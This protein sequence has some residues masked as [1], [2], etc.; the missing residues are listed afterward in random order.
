VTKTW[1]VV[2]LGRL[3]GADGGVLAELVDDRVVGRPA[4]LGAQ[5]SRWREWEV[6]LVTGDPELLGDVEDLFAEAG[7]EPSRT[8]QKLARVLGVSPD[9]DG[10][11]EEPSK[12]DPARLLLH[13]WLAEQVREIETLDPVARRGGEEGVHGMRKACRRLRAA[14]ATYRPMFDRARTDPVRDELRWLARSLGPARDDEVVLERLETSFDD[15][16]QG[17]D[18]AA[19]RRL[20]ESYA[21]D[22]AVQDRAAV[23]SLLGSRRYLELRAALDELISAPPWTDAAEEPARDVLP[24]RARKEGK[25][26]RRR[27]RRQE[28]PHEVRKAA[29]RLRYA[30]EV[31]EPAWGDEAAGPAKA[32]KTLTQV[33]GDRQDSLAAREWLVDLE[34]QARRSGDGAFTLGRL[35]ALEE[36][37]EADALEEARTAY[38]ELDSVRW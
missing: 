1:P 38:E 11:A 35:H 4:S 27:V 32:A 37:R 29:K 23:G 17:P 34:A 31:L 19:A 3:V 25:R 24:R 21:T 14:L 13:E 36:A 8:Q 28:D 10:P 22:R 6:E 2:R 9:G 26:L 20:L 12:K 18:V 30:Y 33:L 16:A 7:A 5:S 15:E